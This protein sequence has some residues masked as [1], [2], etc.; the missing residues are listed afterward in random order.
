[1]D[2]MNVRPAVIPARQSQLKIPSATEET[3]TAID[4]SGSTPASETD[5]FAP[6]WETWDLLHENFV[7]Q[8]LNDIDL[9]A[10]RH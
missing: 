1:M 5:L 4:P 9:I 7:D 3:V 8:P 6:F 2:L 10:R